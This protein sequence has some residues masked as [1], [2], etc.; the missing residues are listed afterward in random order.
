MGR[1]LQLLRKNADILGTPCSG[2]VAPVS[3]T[4]LDVYKRQ[5]MQFA[6]ELECGDHDLKP[7][8][9]SIERAGIGRNKIAQSAGQYRTQSRQNLHRLV[10][11]PLDGRLD[12]YKRQSV[13][14]A[15][16]PFLC[17]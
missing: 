8:M 10:T 2:R 7:V 6:V 9:K 4:H 14:K 16:S 11:V 1:G 15:S 5:G 3:Y 13:F 12:V 17:P